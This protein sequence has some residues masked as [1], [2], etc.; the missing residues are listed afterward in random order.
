VCE[1]KKIYLRELDA[2]VQEYLDDDDDDD[3]DD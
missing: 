1:K 3:D 2:R